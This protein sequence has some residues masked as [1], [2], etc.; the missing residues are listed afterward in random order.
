MEAYAR[1]QDD[2]VKI[3]K[4]DV[5]LEDNPFELEWSNKEAIMKVN[6][7]SERLG[8]P[9]II[10]PEKGGQAI[11]LAVNPN[12]NASDLMSLEELER[13]KPTNLFSRLVVKDEYVPHLVPGPHTDFFYAHIYIDVP[14]CRV[15][16]VRD[17][18]ESAGYDTMTREAYARCHGMGANIVSLFLIKQIAQG[19]KSL[20]HAQQEYGVLIKTIGAE[21]EQPE[22][23]AW[24]QSLLRYLFEGY[25]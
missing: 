15:H 23:G 17:L 12:L 16:D 4:K 13:K 24:V 2:L 22:S 21:M 19:H 11:W 5:M 20:V 3:L 25:N 7:M 8:E 9:Q 18:T 10:A 14:N 6:M 1:Y